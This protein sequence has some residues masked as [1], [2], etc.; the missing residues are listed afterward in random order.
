MPKNDNAFKVML[1]LQP[2]QFLTMLLPGA[3][4]LEVLP[5]EL[6][7]ESLYVDAL[8][9]IS[10]NG[11]QY[12]LHLEV[13]TKADP[14]MLGRILQYM[15]M[16]WIQRK[17]PVLPLILYLEETGTPDSPW[18]LDGP[19]GPINTLHFTT[20]KLWER[21]VEEWLAGG[22]N[23]ALIF[24]PLLK[25]ATIA[26]MGQAAELLGQLPDEAAR[27]NAL[28][29]LVLFAIRKFGEAMVTQYI[30]ENAMLDEF[31]AQSEWYRIVLDRGT[32]EGMEKGIEKGIEKGKLQGIEQGEVRMARRALEGRFGKLPEDLLAA[33]TAADEATLDAIVTHITTDSIEQVRARLGL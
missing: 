30:K 23:A 17:L 29:Y 26:S 19:T 6:P 12:I 18:Q 7:C 13:Q 22:V 28:N 2:Q 24:T 32:R 20:V 25:G 1:R 16:I 11:K 21:P 27:G 33:L 9:L 15:G 31:I 4:L 3:I 5:T 8:L 10:Y 14:N